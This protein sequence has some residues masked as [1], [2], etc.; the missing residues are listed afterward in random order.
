MLLLPPTPSHFR[1]LSDIPLPL[2]YIP[3]PDTNMAAFAEKFRENGCVPDVVDTVPSA[4]AQ[5]KRF[6]HWNFTT[7]RY[8][9]FLQVVYEGKEV[10]CG[11]VFTPT[12]ASLH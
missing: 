12:Q 3:S 9:F 4:Q 6:S 8:S 5:V 2:P 10:Q 11:A 7:A 1:I